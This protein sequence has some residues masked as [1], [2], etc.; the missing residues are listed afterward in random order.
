MVV[1]NSER[2]E[3]SNQILNSCEQLIE[4]FDSFLD[5]AIIDTGNSKADYK[6]M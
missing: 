3:F 2:E 4:L 6:N 1:N 5:S